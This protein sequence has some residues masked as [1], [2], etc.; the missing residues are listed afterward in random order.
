MCV[1]VSEIGKNDENNTGNR[2]KKQND[3]EMERKQRG[4]EDSKVV[5]I[6]SN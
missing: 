1:Y 6:K 4:N 2:S 3:E 5:G